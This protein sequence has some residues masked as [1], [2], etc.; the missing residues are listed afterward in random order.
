MWI[1]RDKSE[2][3]QAVIDPWTAVHAGNGLAAGLMDLPPMPT[4][5][6]VGAYEI[7]EQFWLERTAVGRG[8][9]KTS[10]P[11]SLGNAIADIVFFGIGYYIGH[12]WNQTAEAAR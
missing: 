5:A 8:L 6:V 2:Q 12:K 11:E 4:F 1:A 9:F 10:G 7:V 3:N